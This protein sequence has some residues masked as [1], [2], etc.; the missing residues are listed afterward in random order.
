MQ[1]RAVL[2]VSLSS[3]TYGACTCISNETDTELLV[4]RKT[5]CLT[6]LCACLFYRVFL[7]LSNQGLLNP[8]PSR[9][10]SLSGV[11]HWLCLVSVA[12]QLFNAHPGF[13]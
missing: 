5:A 7:P 13:I 6:D 11:R 4:L 1:M 10:S 3:G 9:T 8:F 12:S 2:A